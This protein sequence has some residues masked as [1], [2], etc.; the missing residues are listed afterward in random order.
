MT[1]RVPHRPDFEQT[2]LTSG[3]VLAF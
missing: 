2:S 1:E 3:V